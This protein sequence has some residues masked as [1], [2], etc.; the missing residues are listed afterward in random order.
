[1][2]KSETVRRATTEDAGGTKF[3]SAQEEDLTID[4]T[5]ADEMAGARVG[6]QIRIE[7]GAMNLEAWEIDSYVVIMQRMMEEVGIRGADRLH[8][9]QR[10]IEETEEV[11][12]LPAR[13]SV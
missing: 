9:N 12:T 3:S 10:P 11:M 7:A 13:Q 4:R 8:Q 6:Q 5:I 2:E 1:V